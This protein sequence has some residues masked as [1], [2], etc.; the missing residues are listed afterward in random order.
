MHG[1]GAISAG[2]A[3]TMSLHWCG[4]GVSTTSDSPVKSSCQSVQHSPPNAH[5]ERTA[6]GSRSALLGPDACA[7]AVHA[8]SLAVFGAEA[9]A[10]H[11]SAKT[12]PASHASVASV[13]VCCSR[14]RPA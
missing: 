11:G 5:S 13:S 9:G 3:S 4:D 8:A 10:A 1:S 2:S 14:P 7:G 12:G 6:T